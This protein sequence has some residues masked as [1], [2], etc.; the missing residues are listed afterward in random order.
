MRA[1]A[2]KPL[3]AA[4]LLSAAACGDGVGGPPPCTDD[5]ECIPICEARCGADPVSSA[6][7]D[8]FLRAC[9]CECAIEVGGA[10]IHSKSRD[11]GTGRRITY[12]A[13]PAVTSV[14]TH[15]LH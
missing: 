3:L 14:R 11:T 2:L 9:L 5:S 4:V 6:E 10:D 1:D 8:D 13:V 7:C 15:D 12:A